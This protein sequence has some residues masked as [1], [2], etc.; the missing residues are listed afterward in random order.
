MKILVGMSGGVDSS[1]AALKLKSMGHEVEGAILRMH[2]Y[3]ETAAAEEAAAALG[4]PLHIIDCTVPFDNIVVTNFI[5]EY[6]N[7]RTP[8]PCIVC[9]SEVKFVYLAKFAEE[10][11]FSAVATG[12]YSKL[13]RISESGER[14][15][16]TAKLPEENKDGSS[17]RYAVGMSEDSGKDQT[18]MLWRLS[19]DILSKLLFVVGDE[20]KAFVRQSTRNAGLSAADRD[21]SQEICFLPD[22]D[23]ASF[24]EE[25][26][27]PSAIGDFLDEDGKLLG[28]HKGIIR[29][30][31]GQRRGLGI[32]A[33]GRIFVKKIDPVSNNITLSLKD[34]TYTRV[35]VTRLV[36]QGIEPQKRGAVLELSVKLRYAAKPVLA[37]VLFTDCGAEIQ[38]SEPVRAVTPGQSAVFYKDGIVAFGG[39]I[40]E[41]F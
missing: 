32:S 1:Y 19:Q 13:Y 4:I 3:T 31:V 8:N 16:I 36:F 5:N 12:H 10:H 22:G 25:R 7:A 24:I 34:T 27:E 39:F 21:D 37:R 9:N 17:Y 38:L 6:K 28:K 15:E 2:Q 30:T 33:S 14:I 29:Y 40:E 18:Y 11:G 35:L 26:T 20:D 23:Y 41:A